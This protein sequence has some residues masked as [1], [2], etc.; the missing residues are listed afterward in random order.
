MVAPRLV[1]E[2]AWVM[3]Q[4]A[5]IAAVDPRRAIRWYRPARPSRM[6]LNSLPT[7]WKK[8][9]YV[10]SSIGYLTYTAADFCLSIERHTRYLGSED[11]GEGMT[12]ET[13]C[14]A[15][16]YVGAM[17]PMPER[18]WERARLLSKRSVYLTSR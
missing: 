7:P 6:P 9:K 16:G 11:R 1:I 12:Q 4:R 3:V 5:S 18:N 10:A 13:I 8:R 15:E 17:Y 14:H 2:L